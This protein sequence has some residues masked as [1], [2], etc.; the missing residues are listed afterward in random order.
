MIIVPTK[1]LIALLILGLP[2][3]LMAIITPA[4]EYTAQG[5]DAID[6][7]SALTV[8]IF[9][10]P[11]Y[12]IYGLCFSQ[13]FKKQQKEPSRFYM[14]LTALCFIIIVALMPNIV[15]AVNEQSRANNAMACMNISDE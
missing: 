14:A 9:A 3:A 7:D 10:I 2:I 13:F 4:N 5:L 12:L 15:A 8:F 11:A 1:I 6:C